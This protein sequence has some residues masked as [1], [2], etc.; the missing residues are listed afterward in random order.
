MTKNKVKTNHIVNQTNKVKTDYIVNQIDI[1][2][3][4]LKMYFSNLISLIVHILKV[5]LFNRSFYRLL[6]YKETYNE[7]QYFLEIFL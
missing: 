2:D 7:R 5:S 3:F 6:A 4:P 1:E